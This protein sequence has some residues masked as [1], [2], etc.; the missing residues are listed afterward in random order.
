MG[1]MYDAAGT[2]PVFDAAGA[3]GDDGG[4]PTEGGGAG[5]S[6]GGAG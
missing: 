5:S 1:L 3:Q 4:G 6:D 2:T